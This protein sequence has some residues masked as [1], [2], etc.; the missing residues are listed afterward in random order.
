MT[1]GTPAKPRPDRR[2][3]MLS[4]LRKMLVDAPWI[5]GELE[6]RGLG[7]ARLGGLRAVADDVRSLLSGAAD[8]PEDR[9]RNALWV[10][11][12][13]A[14]WAADLLFET[15][16]DASPEP[17]W[18]SPDAAGAPDGV[19]AEAKSA[20]HRANSVRQA[21]ASGKDL[22]ELPPERPVPAAGA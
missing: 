11:S 10:L 16:R 21:A 20:K 18:G 12:T 5:A 13:E 22:L 6:E 4:L 17:V 8:P 2:T 9:I 14:G 3:R 15:V 7:C 19:R 1:P